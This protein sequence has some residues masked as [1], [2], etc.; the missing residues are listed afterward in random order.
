MFADLSEH[1]VVY[2]GSFDP[3]HFGH[4]MACL[5]LLE[6]H[7]AQCV[8][9]MPAF[10]HAFGKE[11][12][13]F[14]DRVEMCEHMASRL[15]PGLEVSQAEK[16]VGEGGRTLELLRYLQGQHP[17]RKFALAVGAD[18]LGE[19]HRWH[20]WDII[21]R[22]FKVVYIGRQGYPTAQTESLLQL[23]EISSTALRRMLMEPDS[24]GN[25][26]SALSA[27]VPQSVLSYIHERQLYWKK[28]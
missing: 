5:Y 7:R 8:W 13:A 26:N 22:E 18:I 14:E 12:S 11:M 27:L 15:G 9:L 17:T 3:P 1:I 16:H 28:S 20:G 25:L 24:Q 21:Q 4:Q 19:V 23:P 2:G 6:A 10:E